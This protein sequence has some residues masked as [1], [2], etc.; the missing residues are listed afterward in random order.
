MTYWSFLK[1]QDRVGVFDVV[2]SD[3][4][5]SCL[6][7]ALSLVGLVLQDADILVDDLLR[8]VGIEAAEKAE[9]ALFQGWGCK[10]SGN[11]REAGNEKRNLHCCLN[12]YERVTESL[13]KRR[14]AGTTVVVRGRRLLL[15]LG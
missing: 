15:D 4:L 9:G 5:L 13:S 11:G 1:R 10:R 7:R 6:V 14:R 12:W 8:G 2:A 3:D